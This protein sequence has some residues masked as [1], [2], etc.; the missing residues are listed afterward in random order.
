MNIKTSETQI[1]NTRPSMEL[2]NSPHNQSVN[3]KPANDTHITARIMNTCNREKY[4]DVPFKKMN[5]STREKRI[6]LNHMLPI[7]AV[8]TFWPCKKD[9]AT[10]AS[11]ACM[12]RRRYAAAT[13]PKPRVHKLFVTSVPINVDVN[14]AINSTI[15]PSICV[16]MIIDLT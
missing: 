2:T 14:F 5:R 13:I 6:E 1:Q 11:I 12:I 10:L 15:F 8:S 7:T 16:C 4:F 9:K 3:H